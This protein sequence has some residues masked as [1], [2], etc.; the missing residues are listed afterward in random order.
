MQPPPVNLAGQWTGTTSQGAQF[1]F[2]VSADQKIT[3]LTVGRNFNGC[4]GSQT[5]SNLSLDTVAD[6]TCIPGPCAP[7]ITAYRPINFGD[8][9]NEGPSTAVNG[10]FLPPANASGV[11]RFRDFPGCGNADATWDVSRR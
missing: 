10:F 7:G 2:T 6:V 5:F 4:S 8:G 3:T 9:R 1:G 11:V